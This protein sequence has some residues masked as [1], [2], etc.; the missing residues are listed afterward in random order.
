MF[1]VF[2]LQ[3]TSHAGNLHQY[4]HHTRQHP[5]HLCHIL[6]H[7]GSAARPDTVTN[8]MPIFFFPVFAIY[9]SYSTFMLVDFPS[10]DADCLEED[11]PVSHQQH[12]GWSVLHHPR[13]YLC[14]C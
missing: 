7:Q 5:L 2:F 3:H 1:S 11:C 8:F 13:L 12:A 6:L 4:L 14:L 9:L 10:C